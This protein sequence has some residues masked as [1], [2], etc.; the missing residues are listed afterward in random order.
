M[1]LINNLYCSLLTVPFAHVF[2]RCLNFVEL[3]EVGSFMRLDQTII[4]LVIIMTMVV[5][6]S[7]QFFWCSHHSEDTVSVWFSR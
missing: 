1:F 7:G 5:I 6:I 2:G 4:A 3:C